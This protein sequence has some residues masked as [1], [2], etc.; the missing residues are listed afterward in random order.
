MY[1]DL[2]DLDPE[3]L[4]TSD[5]IMGEDLSFPLGF[6]SPSNMAKNKWSQK[7]RGWSAV[8]W[9]A[10]PFK[11]TCF[12]DL[13]LLA[14]A[15]SSSPRK[16]SCKMTVPGRILS[17]MRSRPFQ[18]FDPKFRN[19]R[20]DHVLILDIWGG[21][22]AKLVIF[23]IGMSILRGVQSFWPI[24]IIYGKLINR[25]LWQRCWLLWKSISGYKHWLC[26]GAHVIYIYEC[27]LHRIRCWSSV[28]Q[29]SSNISS[30][31]SLVIVA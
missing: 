20:L 29:A 8:E 19:F 12:Y 6:A 30:N 26:L 3:A 15:M 4:Q 31:I 28:G 16:N 11:H 17:M 2:G 7:K 9:I 25:L 21:N 18:V 1:P 13:F 14:M 24:H 5:R 27:R 22:Y 10:T 23:S